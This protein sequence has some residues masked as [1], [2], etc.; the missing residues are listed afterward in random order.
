MDKTCHV[1]PPLVNH[2]KPRRYYADLS[3]PCTIKVFG[4]KEGGERG[5]EGGK[6]SGKEEEIEEMGWVES[7]CEIII[8]LAMI[9]DTI[10]TDHQRRKSIH[11]RHFSRYFSE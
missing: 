4:E 6:I 11:R 1:I 7:S 9:F 5:R 3:V 2:Y 8:I 10:V